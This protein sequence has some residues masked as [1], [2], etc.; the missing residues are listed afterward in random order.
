MPDGR[1]PRFREPALCGSSFGKR[2]VPFRPAQAS[3]LADAVK[4]GRTFGTTG[5]PL[6]L[7]VNGLRRRRL[8]S[9]AIFRRIRLIFERHSQSGGRGLAF[10]S[11]PSK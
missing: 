5:P 11:M 8:G 9:I 4:V 2:D 10:C 7:S 3:R 6:F 1:G